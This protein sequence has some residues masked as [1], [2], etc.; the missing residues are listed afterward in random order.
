MPVVYLD[1][2]KLSLRVGDQKLWLN[3][4]YTDHLCL[5]TLAKLAFCIAGDS[6]SYRGANGM[7]YEQK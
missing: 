7:T 4:Y 5:P 6:C 2:E 3:A 1:Q